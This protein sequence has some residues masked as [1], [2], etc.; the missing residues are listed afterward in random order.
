MCTL[1]KF[2][3]YCCHYY[4]LVVEPPSIKF[5][6]GEDTFDITFH[7]KRLLKGEWPGPRTTPTPQG[8][9]FSLNRGEI[10][11]AIKQ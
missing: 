7:G 4:I 2:R 10:F 5:D 11:L 1:R 9:L 8:N 6:N 3:D